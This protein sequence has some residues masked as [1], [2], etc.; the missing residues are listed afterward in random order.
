MALV[1]DYEEYYVVQLVGDVSRKSYR[2][3]LKAVL[4]NIEDAPYPRLIINLRDMKTKPD[5][6]RYWFT[7]YFLP[8]F[9]RHAGQI[10]IAMISQTN[11]LERNSI[12][13]MSSLIKFLG[14]KV[15]VKF[16]KQVFDARQWIESQGEDQS[17][18]SSAINLDHFLQNEAD[19]DDYARKS[20]HSDKPKNLIKAQ[21]G[22]FRFKVA[23]DPKGGFEVKPTLLG[24]LWTRFKKLT[25]R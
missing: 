21:K 20:G 17:Q 2:E 13:W 22:R 12:P 19:W 18:G 9:Y 8:K 3:A 10:Y 16:F 25:K 11:K 1:D 7:I 15:T 6:G 14:V 5:L 4:A 24:K 23:F